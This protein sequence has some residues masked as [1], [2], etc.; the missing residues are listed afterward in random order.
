M[1]I[2]GGTHR[3][4]HMKVVQFLLGVGRGGNSGE[5]VGLLTS[6]LVYDESVCPI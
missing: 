3:L 6:H 4:S 1:V 2:I 5:N